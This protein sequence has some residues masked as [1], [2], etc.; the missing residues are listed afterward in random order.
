MFLSATH[1]KENNLVGKSDSTT[2][3]YMRENTVFADAFNFF[4]HGGRQVIDSTNLQPLDTTEIGIPHGKDMESTPVQYYRDVLKSVNAMMDEDA[5]YLLLGIEAQSNVHYAMPVRNMVYDSL[6]YAKQ[7]E[8][9]VQKHR[10]KKD[11]KGHNSGEYLSG[12][13]KEDRLIP[14]ITLVVLFSPGKWDGPMSLHEMMSVK[15]PGILSLIPDYRIHLIEPASILE[16]DLKKFKTSLREVMSFI[17]Y[18][19]DRVKIAE[20]LENDERFKTLEKN[21]ALV[22]KTCTKL[23]IRVEEKEEVVD[24]CQAVEDM[25]KEAAEKA[26]KQATLQTTEK[27]LLESIRNLMKNLGLTAEQAMKA[28]GVSDTEQS[29]LVKKIHQE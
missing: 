16:E 21:A 26:V 1:R 23:N 20:M 11:F 29:I 6:Q 8:E 24:V 28:L 17:K 12:F 27:V 22:I 5:A 7:V 19:K 3:A 4:I 14:V 25:K 13:F 10:K 2:K 9:T 18:S 15:E